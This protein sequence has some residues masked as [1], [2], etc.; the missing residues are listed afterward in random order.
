MKLTLTTY[1]F[2][3]VFL[4]SIQ[5]HSQETDS[6]QSAETIVKIEN[7]YKKGKTKWLNE[8]GF[9]TSSYTWNDVQINLA[10][11]KAVKNRSTGNVLGYTGGGV[12]LFGLL[13]NMA[14]R[15]AYEV[16][17]NDPDRQFQIFKGPYYLGGVLITSSLVLHVNALSKLKKAK[18]LREK[19]FK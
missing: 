3:T 7:P 11:D 6:T 17:N 4:F 16:S 10:L 13:A 9:N 12:I 18:D 1:L 5:L 19:K 8:N 15:L 2:C 14:G